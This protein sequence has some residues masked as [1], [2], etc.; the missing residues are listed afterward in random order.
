MRGL[1]DVQV[2]LQDMDAMRRKVFLVKEIEVYNVWKFMHYTRR[3][4][5]HLASVFLAYICSL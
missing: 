1:H 5:P 2:L 4:S 3:E